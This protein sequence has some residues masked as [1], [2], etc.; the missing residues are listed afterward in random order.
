MPCAAFMA[1]SD[2]LD[3]PYYTERP[4][5]TVTEDSWKITLGNYG[6]LFQGMKLWD[7]ST[8][9]AFH[10]LW[11]VPLKWLPYCISAINHK[12]QDALLADIGQTAEVAGVAIPTLVMLKMI[13]D[14]SRQQ[15]SSYIELRN[16]HHDLANDQWSS[17][18]DSPPPTAVIRQV[19][20]R[21]PLKIK[22]RSND[23]GGKDFIF[24]SDA[25]QFVFQWL[26]Y[27]GFLRTISPKAAG[28]AHTYSEVDIKGPDSQALIPLEQRF[29]W[30][31]PIHEI[32]PL[33]IMPAQAN[34]LEIN[35]VSE[36]DVEPL[37]VSK[38]VEILFPIHPKP[39]ASS[40]IYQTIDEIASRTEI[41]TH[42]DR[43]A[44][45]VFRLI[46]ESEPGTLA[47]TG[48]QALLFHHRNRLGVCCDDYNQLPLKERVV[49]GDIDVVAT[50]SD[51]VTAFTTQLRD[52]EKGAEIAGK[53]IG[54][55]SKMDHFSSSPN[56][57]YPNYWGAYFKP[58]N[59]YKPV[60]ITFY[61]VDIVQVN[62]PLNEHGTV[63]LEFQKNKFVPV[64][65]LDYELE[66]MRVTL[67]NSEPG[68]DEFMK[69]LERLRLLT[70]AE[71]KKLLKPGNRDYLPHP[72][73]VR[74]AREYHSQLRNL[75][76]EHSGKRSYQRNLSRLIKEKENIAVTGSDRKMAHSPSSPKPQ[77]PALSTESTKN[78]QPTDRRHS[79]HRAKSRKAYTR[80]DVQEEPVYDKRVLYMGA[81]GTVFST[82]LLT[83]AYKYYYSH[84]HN[85]SYI[86]TTL[87][88]RFFDPYY[89]H[90]QK[91]NGVEIDR[92][93]Q[94]AQNTG[95]TCQ[96]FNE[97]VYVKLCNL[98][99]ANEKWLELSILDQLAEFS[100]EHLLPVFGDTANRVTPFTKFTAQMLVNLASLSVDELMQFVAV[101]MTY[102]VRVN[103]DYDLGR[104]LTMAMRS[105]FLCGVYRDEKN[106]G[107]NVY[108]QHCFL[109]VL[110]NILV[111][112]KA[113]ETLSNTR[114][115]RLVF[116][117]L[118][119]PVR[120][121]NHVIILPQ[122]FVPRN[123]KP[124]IATQSYMVSYTKKNRGVLSAYERHDN[125]Q[126]P[127]EKTSGKVRSYSLAHTLPFVEEMQ[128]SY[129][130]E[131]PVSSMVYQSDDMRDF[132]GECIWAYND[133]GVCI[134]APW[135]PD[136]CD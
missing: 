22:A 92:L 46:Q 114:F 33:A 124:G 89:I 107:D 113:G 19:H 36:S 7:L 49:T 84:G 110:S 3:D 87:P 74:M 98:Y 23:V 9:A 57:I 69:Q 28:Y 58:E 77:E 70:Q 101:V 51:I 26:A 72:G 105:A 59:E 18:S 95:I 94:E 63:N 6:F 82:A 5:L 32:A 136:F 128:C 90:I 130:L 2:H 81:G 12:R 127:P 73:L 99:Q 111:P 68:G 25:T 45:N 47:V 14:L 118:K 31:P 13:A 44:D 91:E 117:S 123:E 119:P 4:T 129:Y 10:A 97:T 52:I 42:R 93:Q 120:S 15:I 115:L 55:Y 86:P 132:E 67:R 39:E 40:R 56:P 126:A 35:P 122:V 41:Q 54:M 64:M 38:P 62:T 83:F 103:P 85:G 80:S 100:K 104:F 11:S 131:D 60:F 50:S 108:Y 8:M 53:P 43:I 116:S 106:E 88:F 65:S 27:E 75:S 125:C 133:A 37:T 102:S 135:C 121:G 30:R 134:S 16:A 71:G 66:K 76:K 21:L 112:K 20:D 24:S 78:S 1:R 29:V 109:P 34:N 96:I 61:S 48:G 17:D 79:R